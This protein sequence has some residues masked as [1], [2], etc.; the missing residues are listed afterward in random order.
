VYACFE[1]SNKTIMLHQ[2]ET[3][4]GKKDQKTNNTSK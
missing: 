4:A 1:I 2:H 3:I